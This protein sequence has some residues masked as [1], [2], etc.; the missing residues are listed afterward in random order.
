MPDEQIPIPANTRPGDTGVGGRDGGSILNQARRRNNA[1]AGQGQAPAAT[2]D[3]PAPPPKSAEPAGSRRATFRLGQLREG[4]H[5]GEARG[6]DVGATCWRAR[7]LTRRRWPSAGSVGETARQHCRHG[8]RLTPAVAAARAEGR[9]DADPP[10]AGRAASE[11]LA[12]DIWSDKPDVKPRAREDQERGCAGLCPVRQGLVCR[13]TSTCRRT[14]TGSPRRRCGQ[15]VRGESADRRTEADL[16]AQAQARER[17]ELE[18]DA[19]LRHRTSG[20]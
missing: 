2:P 16:R 19:A 20:T 14:P 1:D 17:E 4:G 13:M 12:K 8:E 18:A 11:E 6:D 3:D 9:F 15:E 10:S 7:A 5:A